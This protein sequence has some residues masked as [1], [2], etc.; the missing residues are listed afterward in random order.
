[1][2]PKRKHE[3]IFVDDESLS[4][5][6]DEI[7]ED[8]ISFPP[9]KKPKARVLVSNELQW[10]EKYEPQTSSD[11]CI[12][13]RKAKEIKEV[14]FSMGKRDL[15][16]RLL[17]L[18]GPSGCSKST[19]IKCFA[20]EL[21]K[22]RSWLQKS[23]EPW[24][25]ENTGIVEYIES[26]ILDVSQPNQ[27]SDFLDGCRYRIG[28]NF[29]VVLIEELPNVFH[30]ETL[31]TFRR[32]LSEWIYSSGTELPPVVLC[33]TEVELASE[34]RNRGY[35]NIENNLT[36]ETLLGMDL[37]KR[38]TAAG[39]IKR[40]KMLP[41]AKT[42]L[43]K[44]LNRIVEKE[45]L[46]IPSKMADTVFQPMYDSG[47]V[48]SLICNLQFW[49]LLPLFMEQTA[50]VREN[51]LTLFHAVGKVI[52][53]S[54]KF[55]TLDDDSSDYLSIQNVVDGYNNIGLLHLAM[56][57]NY[58]IYNG[59]QFD[60]AVA[61]RLVDKLSINDT[62]PEEAQDF[63]LRA[64]RSE[65]RLVEEMSGRTQPMKF[66]RHFKM[67]REANKV[68][69]EIHEYVRYVG[70]P[71][72]LFET[73]NLYDGYL[74][75]AIYNS[76][77]YKLRH[78]LKPYGYNRLGGK[79]KPLYADDDLP[80]LES[81]KEVAAGEMDQFHADIAAKIAENGADDNDDSLSEEIDDSD[82]DFDDT[83]D[84]RLGATQR[85]LEDDFLDDPQLDMLVSQGRL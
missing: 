67:L 6:L 31:A 84:S 16:T 12:N 38:A 28:A 83:L 23:V 13:P 7:S 75:P 46:R 63:G 39:L 42:F 36:M 73:A 8:V 20:K 68:Q 76:F 65:L 48:R 74:L 11:V 70:G 80:V 10:T 25:A 22:D 53:S 17:V 14:L 40:I 78:G 43:K 52:H 57:E 72:V 79:F 58:G 44:T 85:D 50:L 21:V 49:A 77:G 61:A 45:R 47:D 30:P 26:E 32:K 81:E 27:F 37:A 15:E 55:A 2:G 24:E 71:H 3:P 59:L 18:T 35:Y 62:F 60:I 82:D 66:P 19:I 54:S 29:A 5:D 4:E 69:Q 41:V 56:L 51:H 33:L 64:V 9:P 1:M 34:N